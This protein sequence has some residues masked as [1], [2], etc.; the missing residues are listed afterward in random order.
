L[1]VSI[2]GERR[3]QFG[4]GTVAWGLTVVDSLLGRANDYYLARLV[5][6][7]DESTAATV[8][9]LADTLF[10]RLAAYYAG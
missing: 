2:Y 5:A 4:A 1:Q 7:Y 6:P 9:G 10:P 8:S 3:G